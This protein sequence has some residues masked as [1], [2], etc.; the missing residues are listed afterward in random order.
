MIQEGYWKNGA[1]RN[2]PRLR[3][4]MR[5]NGV[6]EA[7]TLSPAEKLDTTKSVQEF[8]ADFVTGKT[9][10]DVGCIAHSASSEKSDLWLHGFIVKRASYTLGVDILEHDVQTLR[11]LGYNIVCGDVTTIDLPEKFDFVVAG[12]IIEHVSNP[13][14]F[15]SN[16]ARH[17]KDGGRLVI[18]TPNCFFFLHYLEFL[19]SS[20]DNRWNPE[21]VAWYDI[22]TL[23]NMLRTNGYELVEYH[24]LTRSKK[25]RRLLRFF[26]L[27]L[28]GFLS[29]TVFVLAR[30]ASTVTTSPAISLVAEECKQE[31]PR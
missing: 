26:H 20:G 29:S 11:E 5:N 7:G 1:K 31:A 16:M 22:F 10:L 17:L 13:G 14:A 23:G 19:F 18:T 2:L 8:V 4:K 3:L 24:Y 30:K 6:I 21:H 28:V 9:V 12:E 25:L 27:P 15:I